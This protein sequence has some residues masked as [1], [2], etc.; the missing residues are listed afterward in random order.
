MKAELTETN[1]SKV[2][3]NTL[4]AMTIP[5]NIEVSTKIASDVHAIKVDPALM[6][7]MLT[8]L[9]TNAVQAMPKGGRLAIEAERAANTVVISVEDTGV[10]IL[11]ENLDRIF[12]PLFT[13]KSIGQGLGLPACKRIV[14]AHGGKIT[15][16][17]ELG[18]GSTFRV[19]IPIGGEPKHE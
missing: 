17:S 7:R 16:E 13:T 4:Q 19:A 8:N 18:K 10:G 2:V 6:R 5:G 14:D 3:Q 12:E 15:V 11:E 1:L 9:V